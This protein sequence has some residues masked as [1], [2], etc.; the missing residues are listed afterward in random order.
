MVMPTAPAAGDSPG[1]MDE[2]FLTLMCNDPELL[3]GAFE[4]IVAAEWCNQTIPRRP[5][6]AVDRHADGCRTNRI[7][8]PVDRPDLSAEGPIEPHYPFSQHTHPR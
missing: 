6:G 4:A 2:E 7:T 5:E 1:S 3:S 8:P